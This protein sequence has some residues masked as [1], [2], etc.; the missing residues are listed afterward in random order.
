MPWFEYGLMEPADS[1]VVRA[2]PEW[3]LTRADG[4][5]W[6]TLHGNHRMAWLNPAHPKVRERFIGLVV[7][8]LKRCSMHG[9]QLDDHSA[10]PVEFGYDDFTRSLYHRQTGQTV[11][12]DHTNRN[13][14]SWRRGLLTNLLR[15]LRTKLKSEGLP[16]K[17]SLSPGPFRQAYNL[18]LQDWELWAMGRLIGE[19]VFKT[20]PTQSLDLHVT[21]VNR[22]FEKHGSG[23][24]QHKLASWLDSA[25]GRHQ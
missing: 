23:V 22:R 16:I 21:S 24:F 6:M 1:A 15:E 13:W 19:L 14:M 12:A 17:I 4:Q 11:H 5:R 2:N 9:L 8:T 25:D 7:E 10:W 20:M 18:W 3:V